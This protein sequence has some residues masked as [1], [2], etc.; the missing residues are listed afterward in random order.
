MAKKIYCEFHKKASETL[1]KHKIEHVLVEYPDKKDKKG[2][3]FV[4]VLNKDI[5]DATAVIKADN[6]GV[7]R[8][9][10]VRHFEM[11]ALSHTHYQPMFDCK[12]RHCG[13]MFKHPVKEAT[14]CSKKCKQQFRYEKMEARATSDN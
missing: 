3:A 2:D 5:H 10:S 1:K 12:C 13:K 14:W 4:V 7:I 11:K 9:K 8:V 6:N